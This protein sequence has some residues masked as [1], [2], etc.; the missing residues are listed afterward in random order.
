MVSLQTLASD[1]DADANCG[2]TVD[3]TASKSLLPEAEAGSLLAEG[4]LQPM[5]P[6]HQEDE[7][8]TTRREF[9]DC[10][11]KQPSNQEE[12]TLDSSATRIHL[13]PVP[14]CRFEQEAVSEAEDIQES[15]RAKSQAEAVDPLMQCWYYLDPLVSLQDCC[16]VCCLCML[17]SSASIELN[18]Q[19]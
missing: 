2:P 12:A 15:L 4:W 5:L 1:I 13:L 16:M 18:A 10:Q 17:S 8:V 9:E 14:Q 7:F 11:T 6:G 19:A 3:G